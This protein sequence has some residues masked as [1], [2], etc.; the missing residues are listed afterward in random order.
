MSEAVFL[1]ISIR[2]FSDQMAPFVTSVSPALPWRGYSLPTLADRGYVLAQQWL[3]A[4]ASRTVK[5]STFL[6]ALTMQGH[7]CS[8]LNLGISNYVAYLY[9]HDS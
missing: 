8:Y 6:D 3:R 5:M 1:L 9:S 2:L 4:Q 7:D